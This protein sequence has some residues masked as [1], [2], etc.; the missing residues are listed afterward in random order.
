M[1]GF[2][3]STAAG[4]RFQYR[5]IFMYS[6]GKH[7]QPVRHLSR[8]FKKLVFLL[9]ITPFTLFQYGKHTFRIKRECETLYLPTLP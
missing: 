2:N 6:A 8:R 5:I 1:N 3:E 7:N 9:K 4:T